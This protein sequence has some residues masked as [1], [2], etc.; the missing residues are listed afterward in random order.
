MA[1]R[2]I[3][4]T[5]AERWAELLAA[6]EK[7]DQDGEHYDAD[8]LLEELEHPKLQAA[9]DT[10]GLWE[11]GL[12][13][14]YGSVR[15]ADQV[16]DVHRVHI[17]GSVH[18]QWRGRGLGTA[19]L[20]WL[21]RRAIELHHERHPEVAGEIGAQ[22]ISTNASALALFGRHGYEPCRYFFHMERALGA[23]PIADAVVPE[24]LRLVPFD[25]AY[26]ENL[27]ET[28]NEVFL[29]HWGSSPR[30]ADTWKVW[31]TGARA[32]RPGLS[33]LVLDGDRIAA[34]SLGYEYVADTAAT[35]IQEVYVGQVG[36]RRE[37][38]GQGLARAV[39]AGTIAAAEAA[40]FRRA[41]LGVD[42][43]NPTG[44]LGLYERLGFRTKTKTIAHRR[45]IGPRGD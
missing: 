20:A 22:A 42:A 19:V 45:P 30:D 27:R 13:V 24:G 32:F 44:A 14:G 3:E 38:R 40:G 31:F 7:V 6:V 28:H 33:F 5:D 36:T 26:D 2:A 1:A 21:D 18:P 29:D 9:K 34:Y 23:E 41:S 16:V 43:E 15:G 10:I 4:K 39:L 12:M 17:E 35:G 25:P 8:D 11:D 37:Y